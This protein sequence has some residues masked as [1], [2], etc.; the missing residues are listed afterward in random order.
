TFH[1]NENPR[2]SSV[3]P[4]NPSLIDVF[5][6]QH[7]KGRTLAKDFKISC[8][9]LDSLNISKPHLLKIDTQG[10]EFE[11]LKGAEKFLSKFS[12][13]VILETWTHEVYQGAPF[14]EDVMRLMR[15][16]GYVLLNAT[17]AALWSYNTG[18]RIHKTN[19]ALVGMD[20][21]YVKEVNSL[22]HLEKDD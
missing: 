16:Y 12:P 17:P 2:T 7:S 11:I 1:L 14:S 10:A 8:K 21:L 5:E 6:S 15:S 22:I 20:L 19:C 4:S 3:Y 13:I 18:N 9:T